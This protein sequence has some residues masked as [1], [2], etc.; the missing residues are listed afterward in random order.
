M[1]LPANTLT[2]LSLIILSV[3]T[4][5]QFCD[6]PI[7]FGRNATGGAGGTVVTV[8][9]LN[10]SGPGSLREA[11][12]ATGASIIGFSVSGT[13]NLNSDIN[14]KSNKT[15]DGNGTYIRIRYNGFRIDNQQN[16][17]IRN[18]HFDSDHQNHGGTGDAITII[19]GSSN[20]WIDHCTFEDYYD[21]LVDITVRSDNV[22]VSWCYFR[23]HD[24]TMLIGAD[25]AHTSDI[26]K[27]N[28]TIHH[29]FFDG[30][31]QRHPRSRFGRIHVLNNYF[32][33]IGSYAVASC[34]DAKTHIERNRFENVSTPSILQASTNYQGYITETGNQRINSG[35][36]TTRPPTFTPSSF[37]SYTAET[38]DNTLRDFL[39][40]YTGYN[41]T[42]NMTLT[43]SGSTMT[44]NYL[45]RSFQWY[46]NGVAISGATANTYTAPNCGTYSVRLYGDQGCYKELIHTI[47][48]GQPA[49]PTITVV[50]GNA[51]FCTGGSVT[52]RSSAAPSG[53]SYQW[54][55]NN[56]DISGATSRDYVVTQQGDYRVRLTGACTTANSSPTFVENAGAADCNGVCGGTAAIDDCGTCSGGNT[57]IA[58]NSGKDCFGVC[59]GSATLDCAGVCGGSAVADCAGVCGGNAV[60]D[61]AGVC[62]GNAA[63]DCAGGCSGLTV[64]CAGVCGG[65]AVV[66]CAGVCGGAA[67]VDCHGDCNGTASLNDCG[68]CSGGTTGLTPDAGKDCEGVCFG[69]ATVDC[70]GVCNGT[71][72]LDSCGICLQPGDSAFNLLCTGCDGVINS[73]FEWD[74][75]GQCLLPTDP[76]FNNCHISQVK[77]SDENILRVHLFPNP[78]GKG[79]TFNFCLSRKQDV[80]IEIKI[81]NTFG[82]LV[83]QMNVSEKCSAINTDNLAAGVFYLHPGSERMQAV[84]FAVK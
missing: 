61:C 46:R 6:T 50:G 32:K 45:A 68:I 77:F 47:T 31:N 18:L 82:K 36:I 14:V 1:V 39:M 53:Y 34:A 65:S 28:V 41:K 37:Y 8:T 69:S 19:N 78:A 43:V 59:G 49:V 4:F 57:G 3:D 58:P 44:A 73:G 54:S 76:A 26:G 62:G 56:A 75:C 11:L 33:D 9:N 30:T 52:L 16:V 40:A 67:T 24:K 81:Y 74:T 5:A 63:A 22:T 84:K 70:H 64:D 71:A 66:D 79:E 38:A 10:N 60:V 13:I 35:T 29:N 48:T 17:I 15:I 27:L 80:A 21:G 42:T 55:R 2:I 12:E 25:D 20:I 23:A 72:L 83:K 51:F 7:G